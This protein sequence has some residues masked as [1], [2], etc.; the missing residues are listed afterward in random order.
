M[1]CCLRQHNNQFWNCKGLLSHLE[2]VEVDLFG[3]SVLLLVHW[4]EKVLHVHH[5][6]QQPVNLILG[7]ILQVGHMISCRGRI[8]LSRLLS[9]TAWDAEDWCRGCL[10]PR[11]VHSC[12]RAHSDWLPAAACPY[13]ELTE[14]LGFSIHC[15]CM[16]RWPG[17][18]V[19]IQSHK[20]TK[21]TLADTA[22]VVMAVDVNEWIN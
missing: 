22:T 19:N 11:H 9:N 15:T 4:H 10:Y 13:V 18:K 2:K 6:P 20:I 7:D 17:R 8:I 3:V 21:L 1:T 12:G 16:C 5:H 14:D